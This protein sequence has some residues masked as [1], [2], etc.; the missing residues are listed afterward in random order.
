MADSKENNLRDLESQR[1]NAPARSLQQFS[2][3]VSLLR[4]AKIKNG[5]KTKPCKKQIYSGYLNVK[6][7][8]S[9]ILRTK[10][11]MPDRKPTNRSQLYQ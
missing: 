6:V 9:T 5:S 1:E 3:F 4:L 10:S 7:K 8:N 2:Q 11:A